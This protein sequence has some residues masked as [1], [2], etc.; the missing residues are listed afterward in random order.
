MVMLSANSHELAAEDGGH[1]FK[2]P[3]PTHRNSSISLQGGAP[4]EAADPGDALSPMGAA[5]VLRAYAAISPR[6]R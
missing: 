5:S 4:D 3:W 6:W 2:E 1:N